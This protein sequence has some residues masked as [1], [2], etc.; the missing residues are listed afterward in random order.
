MPVQHLSGSPDTQTPNRLPSGHQTG[1]SKSLH[2][3]WIPTPLPTGHC[4]STAAWMRCQYQGHAWRDTQ[5]TRAWVHVVSANVNKPLS[6][7]WL[8]RAR[9]AANINK[10]R[11]GSGRVPYPRAVLVTRARCAGDVVFMSSYALG[12]SPDIWED[13]EH[14]RPVRVQIPASHASSA[15]QSPCM[16]TY[17]WMF[18]LQAYASLHG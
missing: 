4:I 15:P 2:R 1:V 12:R 11:V 17:L 6:C 5:Q 10:P 14:F 8:T 18:L 7:N 13:P 3:T 16:R 9:C